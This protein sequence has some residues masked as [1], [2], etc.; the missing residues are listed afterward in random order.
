MP[1][2]VFRSACPSAWDAASIPAHAAKLG[3]EG[4]ARQVHV[5]PVRDPAADETCRLEL[6]VPPAMDCLRARAL[7]GIGPDG[8]LLLA[9]GAASVVD[10][11]G[12][13]EEVVVGLRWSIDVGEIAAEEEP[14]LGEDRP[15]EREHAL[16]SAFPVDPE[17]AALRVEVAD[18]DASQLPS[19]DAEEEQEN[20]ARRSRGCLATVRS[21]GRAS[22]GRRG[23]TRLSA[24]GR[25]IRAAGE[26]AMWPCS[27]AQLQKARTTE[28]TFWRVRGERSPQRSMT[29]RRSSMETSIG[30]ASEGPVVNPGRKRRGRLVFGDDTGEPR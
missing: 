1:S 6:A 30:S 15:A 10:L 26:I 24:R 23:T 27:S 7:L 20:S 9:L 8:E 12:R 14:Q 21:R 11:L 18:L 13:I 25:L 2:V 28:V 3:G 4:V 19:P 22:A 5:H 29:S 17:R 16:L